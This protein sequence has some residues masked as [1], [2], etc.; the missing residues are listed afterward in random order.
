MNPKQQIDHLVDLVKARL[1][2]ATLRGDA[3]SRASGDWFVDVD[4]EGRLRVTAQLAT[5]N[6]EL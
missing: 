6:L 3:P 1:P 4:A 2:E 5:G